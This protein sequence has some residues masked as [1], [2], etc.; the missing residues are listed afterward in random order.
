VLWNA[1]IFQPSGVRT[2]TSVAVDWCAPASGPDGASMACDAWAR[3]T[4]S[5][6][7]RA[8]VSEYRSV[9]PR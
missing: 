7:R 8:W 9:L 4:P 5:A 6:S 1:A 2:S 3:I